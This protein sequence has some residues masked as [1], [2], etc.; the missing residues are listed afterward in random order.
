[1]AQTLPRGSVLRLDPETGV[2]H[3][4]GG[5]RLGKQEAVVVR[6]AMTQEP[7]PE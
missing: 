2:L 3:V 1:M 6:E 5:R 4:V 7:G